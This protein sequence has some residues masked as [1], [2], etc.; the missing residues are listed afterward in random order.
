MDCGVFGMSEWV[1]CIGTA[2]PAEIVLSHETS[3]AAPF[4]PR[5]SRSPAARPASHTGYNTHTPHL[6]TIDPSPNHTKQVG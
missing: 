1:C 4:T 6:S 2:A 3:S 5:V